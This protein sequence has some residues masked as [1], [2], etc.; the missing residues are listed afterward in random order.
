MIY[1]LFLLLTIALVAEYVYGAIAISKIVLVIVVLI[2][3][4]YQ[5]EV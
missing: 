3:I 4:K 5:G 1:L 2:L